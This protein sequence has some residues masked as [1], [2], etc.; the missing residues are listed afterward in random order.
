[1]VLNKGNSGFEKLISFAVWLQTTGMAIIQFL[2]DSGDFWHHY[3]PEASVQVGASKIIFCNE[4]G[5]LLAETSDCKTTDIR[6][7]SFF[8]KLMDQLKYLIEFN[9]C[10]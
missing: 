5:N 3:N 7:V 2:I 4:V 10:S 1:L 9:I 8:R 6:S